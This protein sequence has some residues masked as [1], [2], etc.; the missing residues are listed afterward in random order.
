[1]RHRPPLARPRNEGSGGAGA[2]GYGSVRAHPTPHEPRDVGVDA[3]IAP[4]KVWSPMKRVKRFSGG[5]R[6]DVLVAGDSGV[7][8]VR[9]ALVSTAAP[10]TVVSTEIAA[11][12]TRSAGPER[13][14]RLPY[15]RKVC[16]P[17]AKVSVALRG[18]AAV[19][20]RAVAVPLPRGTD[21]VIGRDVLGRVVK[22]IDF[23]TTPATIACRSQRRPR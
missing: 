7:V 4:R 22:N 16:G 5:L 9:H 6:A 20:V 12:I 17:S 3:S 13:C 15:F 2:D 8:P 21:A 19:D 23:S 11:E 18:C 10:R 14:S 1:M